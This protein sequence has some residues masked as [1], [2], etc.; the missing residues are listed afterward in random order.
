MEGGILIALLPLGLM[1]LFFVSIGLFVRSILRYLERRA[2]S[3]ERM[4][5]KLDRI[6]ELLE[7]QP[8]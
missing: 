1:V 2:V 3:A 5:E 6:I 7:K 4:E 8:T